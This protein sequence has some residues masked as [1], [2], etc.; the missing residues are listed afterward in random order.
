MFGAVAAGNDLGGKSFRF[1]VVGKTLD[2]F[3]NGYLS[4]FSSGNLG[5]PNQGGND[6]AF[7]MKFSP[8]TVP[9][10]GSQAGW[11]GED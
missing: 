11:Q 2:G 9:E 8:V 1:D 10:P 6:D 7:L 4:G 5:S 3:G